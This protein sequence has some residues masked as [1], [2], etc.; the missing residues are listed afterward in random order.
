MDDWPPAKWTG[1]CCP[2]TGMRSGLGEE[3]QLAC[4]ALRGVPMED[5]VTGEDG[6]LGRME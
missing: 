1:R 5:E 4:E 3:G 6:S 2:V